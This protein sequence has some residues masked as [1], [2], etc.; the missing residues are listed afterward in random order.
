MPPSSGLKVEAA[1]SCTMLLIIHPTTSCHIPEACDLNNHRGGNLISHYIF[2]LMFFCVKITLYEWSSPKI[3]FVWNLYLK[4][5]LELYSYRQ[6][7]Y[8]H[9]K[10]NLPGYIVKY[11]LNWKVLPVISLEVNGSN[12][13]FLNTISDLISHHFI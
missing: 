4:R 5:S 2:Y 12:V 6:S 13:W 10:I 11:M 7:P 3:D 9:I 8:M 1:G